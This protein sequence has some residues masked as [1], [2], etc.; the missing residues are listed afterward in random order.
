MISG[1]EPVKQTLARHCHK[2][3]SRR[4]E[5]VENRGVL[6]GRLKDKLHDLKRKLAEDA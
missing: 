5:E 1:M 4:V 6:R 2:A 3:T